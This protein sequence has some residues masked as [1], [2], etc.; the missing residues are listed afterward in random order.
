MS[1][2]EALYLLLVALVVYESGYWLTRDSL[3]FA[4][5][6]FGGYRAVD[7][8]SPLSNRQGGVR[9][10]GLVPPFAPTFV[11]RQ[12]GLS[13]SP[14][15]VVSFVATAPFTSGRPVRED[16]TFAYGEIE[17]VELADRTISVNGERLFRAPDAGEAQRV[18][19]LLNRLVESDPAD[20][21][22]RIRDDLAGRFDA[23]AAR[24]RTDL[25]LTAT[26]DLRFVLTLLFLHVFVVVPIA[27]HYLSV[28][29]I[30]LRAGLILALLQISATA[31]WF[32]AHRRLYP[33]RRGE[34]WRW[35]APLLLFPP[36]TLR[37]VDLLSRPLLTGFH[38]VAGAAAILANERFLEVAERALRDAVHPLEGAPETADWTRNALRESIEELVRAEEADPES[39][40]AP[41]T[42]DDPRSLTHCPRCRA[43]YALAEGDCSDCGVPLAGFRG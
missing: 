41:G 42:P 12:P 40:L 17:Q 20:R 9:F 34:R 21:E 4:R 31:I 22:K 39:L 43:E 24:E 1:E 16:V 29:N 35:L 25:C 6:G 36:V 18:F 26:K 19:D 15:A 38:P 10:G 13:F 3:A 28:T 14:V 32:A 5:R 30:W 27:A 2:G 8:E 33:D 23:A 11:T 7:P 37:A